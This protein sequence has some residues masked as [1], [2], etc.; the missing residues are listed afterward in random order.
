[1]FLTSPLIEPGDVTTLRRFFAFLKV[2]ERY[3]EF[4][5]LTCETVDRA[6]VSGSISL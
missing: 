5:Q 3:Q 6:R 4:R 2:G 1:M